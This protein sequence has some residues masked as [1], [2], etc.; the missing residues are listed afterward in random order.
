MRRI[1]PPFLVA[2][3]LKDPGTSRAADLSL[4]RTPA[5]GGSTWR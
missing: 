3:V 5:C 4:A 2:A 1:V